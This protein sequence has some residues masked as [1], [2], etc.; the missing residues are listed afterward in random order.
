MREKPVSKRRA[1]L[2]TA[3]AVDHQAVGLPVEIGSFDADKIERR[4]MAVLPSSP[5]WPSNP[6]RGIVLAMCEGSKASGLR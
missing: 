3:F 6:T 2:S 5:N 4:G 1:P